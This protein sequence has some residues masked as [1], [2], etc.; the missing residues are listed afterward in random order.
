MSLA[1]GFQTS[2][3]TERLTALGAGKALC[4]IRCSPCDRLNVRPTRD[5][6]AA[7]FSVRSLGCTGKPARIPSELPGGDRIPPATCRG[8]HARQERQRLPAPASRTAGPAACQPHVLSPYPALLISATSLPLPGSADLPSPLRP[9]L[10]RMEDVSL[11]IASACTASLS[12]PGDAFRISHGTRIHGCSS[13]RHD[14]RSICIKPTHS[15]LQTLNH[16]SMTYPIECNISAG[17]VVVRL[18]C[19]ANNDKN[20]VHIEYRCNCLG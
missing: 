6:E 9:S 18:H 17:E 2:S 13:P 4:A 10:P 5:P 11:G 3:R 8:Q 7:R 1:P 19:L 12:I 14:L 15:L 16:R 20:A